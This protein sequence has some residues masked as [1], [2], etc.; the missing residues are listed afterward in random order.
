M[1]LLEEVERA[2]ARFEGNALLN[3]LIGPLGITLQARRY[4]QLIQMQS[5]QGRSLIKKTPVLCHHRQDR[6]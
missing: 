2:I 3:P 1:L 4:N 6:R 5:H